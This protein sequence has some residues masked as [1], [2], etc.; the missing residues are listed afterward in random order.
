MTGQPASRK[1][2]QPT[3]NAKKEP[4]NIEPSEFAG[5]IRRCLRAMGARAGDADPESLRI[6]VELRDAI[7]A[8]EHQAI[9]ALLDEGYSFRDMGRAL[10]VSHVAVHKRF[11][12]ELPEPGPEP[13]PEP[14]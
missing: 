10:G 13:E 1:R 5:M 2:R 12:K 14:D 6:F 8:A 7:D 9:G 4:R 11:N 3:V